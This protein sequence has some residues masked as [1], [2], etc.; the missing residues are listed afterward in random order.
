MKVEIKKFWDISN[1]WNT[2][3]CDN[4]TH[5]QNQDIGHM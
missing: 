2:P 1:N 5:Q 3:Y 4:P